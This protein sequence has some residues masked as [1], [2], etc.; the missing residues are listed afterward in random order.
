VFP[1]KDESRRLRG[2]IFGQIY[3]NRGFFLVTA[4]AYALVAMAV[5]A[6]RIF[7]PAGGCRRSPRCCP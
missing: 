2:R 7:D 1:S 4:A 3:R 5:P 6:E